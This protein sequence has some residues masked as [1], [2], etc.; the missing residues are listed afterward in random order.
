MELWVQRKIKTILL[1]KLNKSDFSLCALLGAMVRASSKD[2]NQIR[3]M[4]N[5]IRVFAERKYRDHTC[6]FMH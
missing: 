3:Q 6:F 4:P 2:C 5:L 1:I